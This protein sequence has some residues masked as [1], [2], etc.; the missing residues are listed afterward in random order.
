MPSSLCWES[1]HHHFPEFSQLCEVWLWSSGAEGGGPDLQ[2]WAQQDASLPVGGR[3]VAAA[4]G[5]LSCKL[6]SRVLCV[7]KQGM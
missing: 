1:A 7:C 6:V 3:W 2:G 4:W 5:A